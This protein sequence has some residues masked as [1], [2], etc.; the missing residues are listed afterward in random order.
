MKKKA[1]Y[2][3]KTLWVNAFM[4]IG[5]LAHQHLG[6]KFSVEEQGAALVIVNMFLRLITNSGLMK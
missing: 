5:V 3:S 1:W 2:K 6:F 4:L